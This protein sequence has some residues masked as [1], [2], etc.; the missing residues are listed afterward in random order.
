MDRIKELIGDSHEFPRI[1]VMLS[2][3][4]ELVVGH[5]PAK[6]IIDGIVFFTIVD[7]GPNNV[8]TDVNTFWSIDLNTGMIVDNS[9]N[10]VSLQ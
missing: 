9:A 2:N 5:D 3:D 10:I 6:R 4:Q 8:S 1:G 7:I